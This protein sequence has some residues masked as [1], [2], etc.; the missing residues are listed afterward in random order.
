MIPILRYYK[1]TQRINTGKQWAECLAWSSVCVPDTCQSR[2]SVHSG[3]SCS[4]YITTS[5][6]WLWVPSGQR[7]R[8]AHHSNPRGNFM[9]ECNRWSIKIGMRE[10]SVIYH[11]AP[12]EI[13]S[14]TAQA[15][16]I[17]GHGTEWSKLIQNRKES[18]VSASLPQWLGRLYYLKPYF[19]YLEEK[20]WRTKQWAINT[21]ELRALR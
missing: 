12:T 2:D 10:L 14:C 19:R 3:L 16:G 1:R 5:T 17:F 20:I 9:P 8:L 6:S 21:W 11:P 7:L 18:M 4:L 15:G 13:S